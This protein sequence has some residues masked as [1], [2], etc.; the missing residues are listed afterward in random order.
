MTA[1]PSRTTPGI[2]RAIAFINAISSN[3]RISGTLASSAFDRSKPDA[4]SDPE[5]DSARAAVGLSLGDVL[6]DAVG[7]SL[8]DA[9]GLALGLVLGLVDGLALGLALGDNDGLAVGAS[10]V[11]VP[12]LAALGPVAVAYGVS[13][14]PASSCGAHRKSR[15][16]SARPC[17]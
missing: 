9:D 6:G 5:N 11:H 7:L 13:V 3:F 2:E 4:R 16:P 12:L 1:I 10:A 17:H 14:A 8:G 15:F